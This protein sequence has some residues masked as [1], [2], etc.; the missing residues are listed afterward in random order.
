M[1]CTELKLSIAD[2]I[3]HLVSVDSHS[4]F[5]L[6]DT[7]SRFV[8]NNDDAPDVV[9]RVHLRDIRDIP[10]IE[11]GRLVFG[12][13]E[14][15]RLYRTEEGYIIR[16]AVPSADN[17]EVS[18]IARLG[19]LQ[20]DWK[21][22]D[23]Y[24]VDSRPR[25]L[26]YLFRVLMVHVV[27]AHQAM[28]FHACGVMDDGRGMI[29]TGPSGSGKTTTANLWDGEE[30]VNVL[31]DERIIV[32]KRNGAFWVYGTPWYGEGGYTFPGGARLDRIFLIKH[33][34]KNEVIS[35]AGMEAMSALLP[36]VRFPSF[37]EWAST[38]VLEM[39]SEL[40]AQVPCYELGF[41]P[42]KQV[43]HMIRGMALERREIC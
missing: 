32:R 7:Y 34:G 28:D 4:S 9:L 14:V 12:A 18:Q 39:C 8:A 25:G 29:F 23:I 5:S 21:R 10:H 22:G 3:V 30:R 35:L 31:S 16:C 33:A 15:Y 42:D 19:I 40:S 24:M 41:V 26:D 11:D 13:E 37:E 38:C 36:R 27:V 20:P 6:S 17:P 43:V 2:I 1:L